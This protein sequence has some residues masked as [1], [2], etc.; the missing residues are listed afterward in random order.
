MKHNYKPLPDYLKIDK[1]DIH[2]QGLI[3]TNNIPNKEIIGI[4]HYFLMDVIVRTPLGGFINH[5]EKPNCIVRKAIDNRYTVYE[6]VTIKNITKDEEITLDY[7][8]TDC[9][10]NDNDSKL[11]FE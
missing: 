5:S 9:V 1:S 2:G 8:G 3:A 11:I 7:R 6:L 10:I 4:T